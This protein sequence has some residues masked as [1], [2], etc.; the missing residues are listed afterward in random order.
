MSEVVTRFL[1]FDV[2]T[3]HPLVYWALGGVWLFLV[4]ASFLSL[5]NL[6]LS[7]SGRV[8]WG[9]VIV[10]VPLVGLLLYSFLCLFRNDWS[11]L[12]PL[13]PQ[14]MAVGKTRSK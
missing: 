9:T 2:V 12:R 10:F 7:L 3:T 6:P 14:K 13:I 4:L 11:F 8:L 1:S 5:A